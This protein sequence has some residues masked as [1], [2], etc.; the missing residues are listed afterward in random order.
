GD[1]EAVDNED[2]HDDVQRIIDEQVLASQKK[3]NKSKGSM[4]LLDV[5]DEQVLMPEIHVEIYHETGTLDKNVG[6][7]VPIYVPS[8]MS[9]YAGSMDLLDEEDEHVLMPEIHVEICH[10]TGTLDKN[11]VHNVGGDNEAVDNEDQHDDVQRIIDEQVLASQKKLNKSKEN[12]DLSYRNDCDSDSDS[13]TDQEKG[14]YR[15][16]MYKFKSGGAE[17]KEQGE[18]NQNEENPPSQDEGFATP[19]RMFDM[20]LSDAVK[21]HEQDMDILMRRIKAKGND[22]KDPFHL[23]DKTERCPLYDEATHWKLKKPKL[24]KEFVMMEQFKECLTYYALA[25]G[26][27]LCLVK[28][29]L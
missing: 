7:D 28:S 27:S 18:P 4:D 24:G 8:R 25:N 20:G 11:V 14:F 5:E 19:I 6:D 2:Q 16:R 23:V 13:E 15:K 17:T 10:E 26:F 1:N 21:E 12:D 3:L 29:L 22:L 9:I